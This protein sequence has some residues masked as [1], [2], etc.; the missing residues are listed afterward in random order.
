MTWEKIMVE[1]ERARVTVARLMRKEDAQA[2]VRAPRLFD[3]M[4]EAGWIKPIVHR[5]RMTLFDQ[6][7]LDGCI[8]RLAN[9]E[10]PELTRS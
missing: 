8:E 6:K 2:Y 10:F 1:T 4:Y 9:G 5:H 7:H 3:L